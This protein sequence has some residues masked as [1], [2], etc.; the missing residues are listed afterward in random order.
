MQWNPEKCFPVNLRKKKFRGISWAE[1]P[2]FL[3]GPKDQIEA[4]DL[5][6][7]LIIPIYRKRKPIFASDTATATTQQ[8]KKPRTEQEQS[9]RSLL[10]SQERDLPIARQTTV[11]PFSK[12]RNKR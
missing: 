1:S 9:N 8:R 3:S 10:P 6:Q 12:W 5:T 2:H 7:K 4:A 11:S